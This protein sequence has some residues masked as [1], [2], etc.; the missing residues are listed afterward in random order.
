[1]QSFAG[2]EKNP[3]RG[4]TFL[5][6]PKVLWHILTFSNS[7][8]LMAPNGSA[9]NFVGLTRLTS[10]VKTVIWTGKI[11]GEEPVSMVLIAPA[12]S[13]KTE[14]LKQ[15]R[16]TPTLEF[17]SDLTSR[18]LSAFKTDIESGKLRHIVILDLI[19]VLSHPR[20][21]ADRTIQT[22][23]G[24][25][26]DGQSSIAD[27]GGV[28]KWGDTKN[29]PRIGALM[30]VTPQVY[31]RKRKMFRDTGFLSRFLPIHY[32]YSPPTIKMVHKAIQNGHV[33]PLPTALVLPEKKLSAKIPD[34]IAFQIS[35]LARQIGEKENT[36]GFRWHRSMRCLIKGIAISKRRFIVNQEDLQDLMEW[37]E[38]FDPEGVTL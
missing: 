36:Y 38:F 27:A 4:V 22:I 14:L 25:I 23:A 30:A 31:Y 8:S 32:K 11:D 1:M 13:A 5:L 7:Q 17:F 10:L 15:F 26:E 29:F 16:G 35:N 20:V 21:T 28:E 3:M 24:L 18:G 12:E 37:T 33:K 6:P 9:P 34:S 2:I 19:R